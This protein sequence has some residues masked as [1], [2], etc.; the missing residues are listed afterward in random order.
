MNGLNTI[1]LSVRL[2]PD[3]NLLKTTGAVRGKMLELQNAFPE[4]ITTSIAYDASEFVSR[5][6]YHICLRTGVCILILLLFVLIV[7]RSCRYMLI[8]LITLA[9]NILES[10]AIYAFAGVPIHIYT[11]AGITVSIGIVIDTSIV[12]IDH[13]ANFRDRRAFS[14]LVA[15]VMTTIAA[16][17]L[18]LLLPESEKVNLKDFVLVISLNLAVSLSVSYAFVPALMDYLPVRPVSAVSSPRMRRRQIHFPF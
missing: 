1:T 2:E 4:E 18:V 14:S 7:S 16:L 11:L 5:E 10:L 17:S 13:Y 3:A 15:A 8:I 9:V 12:M 6:L